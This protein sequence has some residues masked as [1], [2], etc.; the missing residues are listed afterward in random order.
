VF[1]DHLITCKVGNYHEGGNTFFLLNTSY[2]AVY[3]IKVNKPTHSGII[4]I[5][6]YIAPFSTG[7]ALRRLTF[8]TELK[9]ILSSYRSNTFHTK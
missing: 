8:K 5:I 7:I 3:S 9:H 1:G 6:F 4:I 2:L